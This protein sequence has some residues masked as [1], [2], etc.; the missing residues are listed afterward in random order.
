M[1]TLAFGQKVCGFDLL[2]SERNK[3]YV[4]D[5][6]GWSF[7]KNSHKVLVLRSAG[8]LCQKNTYCISLLR[9]HCVGIVRCRWFALNGSSC[10]IA[11]GRQ[12]S[13][14]P[15]MCAQYYDD[16]AGILRSIIL[17]AIA[18][19]RLSL[20][21]MPMPAFSITPEQ[22]RLKRPLFAI[23][24]ATSMPELPFRLS[25]RGLAP[26]LPDA[27]VVAIVRT[28]AVVRICGPEPYKSGS[29]CFCILEPE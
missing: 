28:L 26:S 12:P 14:V 20:P 19:H 29:A 10:S 13:D 17:S 6:N 25:I 2:R 7:V 16:A 21:T 5:V 15:R 1:V 4:C 23:V 8:Y 9:H 11:V 3:S 22:A 27:V 24:T 18:P